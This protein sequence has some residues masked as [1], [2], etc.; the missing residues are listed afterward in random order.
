MPRA[1][2]SPIWLRIEEAMRDS[3]HSPSQ[4]AVAKL[5]GIKQP[6]VSEW[7]RGLGRPTTKNLEALAIKTGFSMEYLRTGRGPKR[8]PA[9][10]REDELLRE[11]LAIWERLSAESRSALLQHAKLL[12]TIQTTADPTRIREVHDE[13]RQA[14]IRFRREKHGPDD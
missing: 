5:L 8:V 14:N 10:S 12:R 1:I 6:S 3:S 7:A 9:V 2:N 4:V 11:L 13:L